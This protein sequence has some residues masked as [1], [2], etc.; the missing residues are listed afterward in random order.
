[1]RV[2]LETRCGCRSLREVMGETYTYVVPMLDKF[3]LNAS[4]GT[5]PVPVTARRFE[6]R[7]KTDGGLPVL[8]ECSEP[9][10][11]RRPDPPVPVTAGEWADAVARFRL[12]CHGDLSWQDAEFLRRHDGANI[13]A[14][15]TGVLIGA[16]YPALSWE[17][18]EEAV[19]VFSS[20]RSL[21]E[22][23]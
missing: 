18:S 22:D 20:L 5:D 8:T 2:I 4:L 13:I 1:M 14:H 6:W 3:S 21:L 12:I 15:K 17:H 10:A 7:G 11:V 23:Q 16:F 19:R 9:I